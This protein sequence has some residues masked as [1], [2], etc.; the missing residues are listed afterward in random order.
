[1][2]NFKSY[3]EAYRKSRDNFVTFFGAALL[4][5]VKISTKSGDEIQISFKADLDYHRDAAVIKA[6]CYTTHYKDKDGFPDMAAYNMENYITFIELAHLP[7][8]KGT[9][10]RMQEEMLR[11]VVYHILHMRGY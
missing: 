4:D 6:T 7:D 5:T 9:V 8:P 3:T 10:Q 1:M 11:K 2:S